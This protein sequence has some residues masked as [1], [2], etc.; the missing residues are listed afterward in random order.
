[1]EVP[2]AIA[3][4][5]VQ[6]FYRSVAGVRLSSEERARRLTVIR[7]E[8]LARRGAPAANEEL[9]VR[10]VIASQRIENVDAR[11]VAAFRD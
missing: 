4:L 5:E 8:R 9:V 10:D 3:L 6:G 7:E 2:D 1:M 11:S